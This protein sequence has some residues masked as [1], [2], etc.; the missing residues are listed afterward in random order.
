MNQAT[1]AP[2]WRWQRRA[3]EKKLHLAVLAHEPEPGLGAF[4]AQLEAAEVG[5]EVLC[6]TTGTLPDY[7]GFDGTI[8]LGGSLGVH[9]SRLLAARRWVHDAVLAGQPYLG[10]CLGGQLLASAL[11]TR[12]GRGRPEVGIHDV[13]LTD[14]AERD[15]L[16]A[17]LPGRLA[18][19]SWHGDDFD[20][21]RGAVPLAGSVRCTYQA[22]RF[23]PAAYG[24]QF[25]PEVRVDDLA[26]WRQVEGYARLASR[27]GSDFDYLAIALRR[28][29]PTLDALA[30]QLL[31]RW[32]YLVAGVAA[33]T[34]PH[35]AAA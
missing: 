16:F 25:H 31:G 17:G 32:L 21:P 1:R 3:K 15:P 14:A 26:R 13:F 22:Y 27:T 10:V 33:L 4:A 8:A 6:T 28:A 5:Y 29:T 12:V 35:V 23:G 11:G 19:L 20:L 30:E 24:L 2:L 9:D 18:V 34:S 7:R